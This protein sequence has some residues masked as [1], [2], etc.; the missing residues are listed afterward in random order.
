MPGA[1]RVTTSGTYSFTVTLTDLVRHSMLN[2]GAIGESE[3]P[4]AQEFA[5]VQFKLNMLVKQWMAKKDFAPGLKIWT[6][7]QGDLFLGYMKFQYQLG[8]SGDNW[9]VGVTG[10]VAG[11]CSN[12]TTTTAAANAGGTTI[13]VSSITNINASD[14]I[15][16][17]YTT[18][19][20]QSAGATD[21]FWTTVNGAPTGSTVTLASALPGAV[22]ASAQVFNFTTKGQR[23]EDFV[24][25]VLRDIYNNDT[26]LN[27]LTRED[28]DALPTKQMPTFQADPTAYLYEPQIGLGPQQTP[29]CGQLFIDCGGAQDVTKKISATWYRPVQDLN[30]PG[31]NPE[32]PHEWYR[33]LVWGLT[34]DIAAMFDAQVTEDM[35]QNAAAA[36]LMAQQ[37]NTETTSF[38]FQVQAG[39]PY[40][41]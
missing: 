28:Y 29:G 17:A 34:L 5:D 6:R 26:Q 15:G 7:Q 23:P 22:A 3:V 9:A 16:V 38:Y 25:A 11:Q 31:D 27:P 1:R 13:Q 20:G 21:L 24:T 2:V 37:S 19:T 40:D 14:F 30:N 35:I 36:L 12:A 8:P 4:T 41:P 18:P 33:A 10:G 39:S 32:Y